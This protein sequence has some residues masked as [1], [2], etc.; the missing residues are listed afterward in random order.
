MI[1]SRIQN[2]SVL[3]RMTEYGFDRVS[4]WTKKE[5]ADLQALSKEPICLELSNGD[6]IVA[7]YKITKLAPGLGWKVDDLLFTSKT[8]AIY[9]AT[10][11]HLCKMDEAHKLLTVDSRVAVLESEK[12]FFRTRLDQA[13]LQN[14]EFKIGLFTSRYIETKNNLVQAKKELSKIINIAKYINVPKDRIT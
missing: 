6:Y 11:L 5:L 2:G 9:Y 8:S 7:T 4:E 3:N 10:M 12:S 13:H 1:K 14:D